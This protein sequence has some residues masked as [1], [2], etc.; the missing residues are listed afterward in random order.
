[1]VAN[2]YDYTAFGS[3]APAG[4]H[5]TGHEAQQTVDQR[6]TY[7]GREATQ[8]PS[9][10]YYRY[11]MY[12]PGV[13]RFVSRDPLGYFPGINVYTISK[14]RTTQVTDPYGLWEGPHREGDA[15]APVCAE[16][17]DTWEDLAALVRL[18]AGENDEWIREAQE[19]GLPSN[20]VPGHTY[21]VPNTIGVYT[22]KAGW[23][24]G[25]ITWVEQLKRIAKSDA[26]AAESEGSKVLR[27]LSYSNKTSFVNLWDK[28]GIYGVVFAGHGDSGT[29][30]FPSDEIAVPHDI[31]P[32]YAL[33]MV[34]VYA[35]GSALGVRLGTT[36][37]GDPTFSS[38]DDHVSD[39]GSWRGFCTNFN[40]WVT[41]PFA[42]VQENTPSWTDPLLQLRPHEVIPSG[43]ILLLAPR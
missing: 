8:D 21:H 29:L 10:M 17:G 11:R 16:G 15:W 33:G 19:G 12:A 18:N 25:L 37:S 9:L 22:T 31:S 4:I 7:T 41:G 23:G 2:R 32:P 13:G 42:L 39:A 14:N 43:P 35:C 34:H 40:N 6:Y 26:N 27:R 30:V 3:A 1:M 20:P 24:D 36:S 5:A 38:W 28:D